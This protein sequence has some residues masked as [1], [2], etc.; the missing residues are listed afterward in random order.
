[1]KK[2]S[3]NTNFCRIPNPYETLIDEKLSKPSSLFR[4]SYPKSVWFL[5]AVVMCLVLTGLVLMNL[6]IE[7]TGV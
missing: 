6:Q 2:Y 5:V 3:S 1:M 7:A 4:M